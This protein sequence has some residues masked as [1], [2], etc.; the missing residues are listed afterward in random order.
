MGASS[1]GK[2]AILL[3][4]VVLALLSSG[5]LS[6]GGRAAPLALLGTLID[7]TGRPP[8]A[9]GVV[10]LEGESIV[11]VGSRK[12]VTIPAGA[13]VYRLEGATI[14]PGFTN[15]HVHNTHSDRTLLEEWALGGVTTVRDLGAPLGQDWWVRTSDP[16]FTT[17]LYAGP[18]VTVPGG[19]PIAGNGFPSLAVTSP[20]DG[21]AK[22]EEL[23]REGADVIKIS[24]ES[25]A[26]PILTPEETIA[27]VDTAHTLGLPVSVHVT[28]VSDLRQAVEAGVDD[29]AHMVRDSVPNT[30]LETMVEREIA[31]VPTLAAI[32]PAGSTLRRFLD[33]GGV[34]ALG[35]DSGYLGFDVGMPMD[36][37]R[38]L[39]QAGMTPMEILVASTQNAA[40]VLRRETTLGTLEAGKQADVL[41]VRGDP[42]ADLE[43]LTDPLLVI[44]KGVVIRDETAAKSGS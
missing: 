20:E 44:H 31:W 13:R 23:A 30:L 5:I 1:W 3:G 25:H 33:L 12:D 40:R 36:E 38:A 22:I 16:R 24:L 10:L 32:G 6:E 2:C 37:I 39:A 19:Y 43:A 34:V 15:A 4:G 8:L 18:I 17:V 28:A 21:R 42:L 14:L 29:I 11:A 9:D 27:I 26:G 7:G 41:V 35:N